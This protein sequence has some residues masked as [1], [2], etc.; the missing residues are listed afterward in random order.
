MSRFVDTLV[1][2]RILKMLAT[3]I[4][5]SDAFRMGIIDKDGK[6]IKNPQTTQELDAYSFLNR[7]VFKVQRALVKSPDRNAKRLLTF[8]AALAILREY[9]EEDDDFDVETLLE[10]YEQD[11]NVAME[12]KLLEQNLVSFKNFNMEEVAANAVGGGAIH[13]IGIGP[14]GEPGRDP[15]LQPMIRRRKKKNGIR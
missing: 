1:A 4:E 9:N 13:G 12:A 8:A 5:Q 10:V 14:K 2:Y 15:V 11:A 3:P 6:K 7:F